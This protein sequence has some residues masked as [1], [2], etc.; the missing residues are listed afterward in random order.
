[1]FINYPHGKRGVPLRHF[2]PNL[3]T[4]ISLC[5]GLASIHFS[6]KPDWDRAILAVLLAAVFDALDGRAARLLKASSPFG[7]VLDSLA[8]F[9]SFGVAPAILLHQWILKEQDIFGL[10][11]VM[12]FALCSALRL[13]RFTAAVKP[14]RPA[15]APAPSAEEARVHAVMASFFVGMP[16]PA[17]AAAVLVPPMLMYSK[18]VGEAVRRF[19]GVAEPVVG[20]GRM[21][22]DQPA[23]PTSSL[24]A[25]TVIVY[26]FLIAYM[27]ISRLPMY[28]FK[29][30]R[31]SKRAVVPLLVTAGLLVGMAVKDTWLTV[32]AL[33]LA[34]LLS[35]P[36]SIL[37][38]RA[39]L[40]RP[41]PA[42]AG[43]ENDDGQGLRLRKA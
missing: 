20:P 9:L 7:A 33:S 30:V 25:W 35:L 4:T 16:T 18:V 10:A 5:C 27:M 8:D 11:A 29:K 14:A 37:S 1:M 23:Q 31:I 26:T 39:Q 34:Y 17:A 3:I 32:S 21:V 13:A 41:A 42:L 15:G 6:L 2:V 38:Q 19:F 28:S 36:L 22:I 43:A 24:I 40:R 12:T